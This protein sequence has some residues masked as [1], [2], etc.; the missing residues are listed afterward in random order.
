MILTTFGKVAEQVDYYLFYC[1]LS[2]GVDGQAKCIYIDVND[3]YKN[4][5]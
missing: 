4:F 3:E 1:L 2:F 5:T